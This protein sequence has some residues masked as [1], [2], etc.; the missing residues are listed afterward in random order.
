VTLREWTDELSAALSLDG[1]VD[2]D[3]LLDVARESA[4]AIER[5]AAPVTTFLL[6]LAAGRAG[7]SADDIQLAADKVRELVAVHQQDNLGR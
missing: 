1:D 5:P 7:G 4:H 2:I 3:L 6:G